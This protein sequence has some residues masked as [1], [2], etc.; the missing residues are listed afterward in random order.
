VG[1]DVVLIP[2]FG[3]TGAAVAF[4][5]GNLTALPLSYLFLNVIAGRKIAIKTNSP[6]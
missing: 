1:L 3:A 6:D 2:Q 4:L 5:I